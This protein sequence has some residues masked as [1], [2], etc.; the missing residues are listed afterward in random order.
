MQAVTFMRELIQA[1]RVLK[2]GTRRLPTVAA[3]VL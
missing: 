3:G 1:M 2:V